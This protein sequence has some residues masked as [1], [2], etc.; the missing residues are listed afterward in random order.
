MNHHPHCDDYIDDATTPAVLRE[1]L[2]YH[3]SPAMARGYVGRAMLADMEGFRA[4]WEG[5]Q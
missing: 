5:D 1:F 3:R 2:D 4:T